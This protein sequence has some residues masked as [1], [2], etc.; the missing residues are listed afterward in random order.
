MKLWYD[1]PAGR[2]EEALPLGNGRLGAM[3]P[4]GFRGC[5]RIQMNED[6]LWYGGRIDRN[7]PDA[8]PNLPKM[9]QLIKQ[10]ELK[11][12]ERLMLTAF[13][14]TPESMKPYQTLG[15]IKIDYTYKV[16]EPAN[17]R[18][19]LD[20]S[21]AVATAE[22]ETGGI[23]YRQ[24]SFISAADQ[25]LAIGY[26]SS[27]GGKISFR[28]TLERGKF[29]TAI[30]NQGNDTVILDGRTGDG[31]VGYHYAIKAVADGGSVATVGGSIVVQDADSVTLLVTA[32][33]TFRY[34][35]TKQT[36]LDWLANAAELG[37]DKLKQRHISG[38]SRYW[39]RV[40][41]SFGEDKNSV[42]PT[43]K[44][45][46]LLKDGKQDT[47]LIPLYFQFGR[48][49]LISSSAP[50]TLPANL[51]GIWNHSYNP[52]WDSKYTININ[53]EMNYWPAESCNLSEFHQ[54][55]F[56]HIERMYENGRHTAKVMYDCRG[57]TAHHNT[58]IWGDTAPQDLYVPATLWVLGAAWFCLHIWEHYEYTTDISFLQKYRFY[59][60]E[61][62]VFFLDFLTPN[63]KGQLVCNPSVSPENTYILPN[64]HHGI[65]CEGCAMDS[66]II[67]ELFMANIKADKLLR[68]EDDTTEMFRQALDKLPPTKIGADG[69]IMEWFEEYGEADKGHRHISHLFA[70][71]PGNEITV[72]GTPDLAEAAKK[73]LEC[74]LANGGGHTGWSRAWII[75][76]WAKLRESQKAYHN[77]IKLLDTSTHPNL[78][79][80]HP[81]FQIDGNFGGAAGI[82]QWFL[83]YR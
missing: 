54:P 73:T 66:Q 27:G 16:G 41:I 77:I 24:E 74:R 61:S 35:D 26:T 18:R 19:E 40:S 32:A 2:W 4:G 48:Y 17:Y 71:Y 36:C 30:K 12:A 59:L 8:L 38:Y 53:I 46:E 20:I 65:M 44:R 25:V 58:D 9:R 68:L 67:S 14:G 80:N 33:T 75:N 70:L 76:F 49:L 7:N 56:D 11:E 34:D 83:Q 21:T 22:F 64:G 15:N 82:A 69:R 60:R 29:F 72:Q 3:I 55:L 63:S 5:D 43:D 13:A 23:K 79:D 52:P 42:I 50:G 6:S 51:Q 10:G 31:G 45:L 78:F 62:A 81:P 47:G 1:A 37:Y 57:F 39:N 28:A